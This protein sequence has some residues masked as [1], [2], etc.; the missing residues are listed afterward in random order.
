MTCMLKWRSRGSHS[1]CHWLLFGP[2]A[3]TCRRQHRGAARWLRGAVQVQ[4]AARW[5]R[6]A[7]T[8][9]EGDTLAAVP[10]GPALQLGGDGNGGWGRHAV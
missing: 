4:G 5:L 8:G 2:A 6:K 1:T 9:C 10:T 3:S 7:G